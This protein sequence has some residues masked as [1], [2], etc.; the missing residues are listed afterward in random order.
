MNSTIVNLKTKMLCGVK[1]GLDKVT[2]ELK[3]T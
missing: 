2:K 1:K 3:K